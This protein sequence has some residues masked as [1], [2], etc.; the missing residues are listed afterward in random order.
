MMQLTHQRHL[1]RG[2]TRSVNLDEVSFGKKSNLSCPRRM[3]G[4]GLQMADGTHV[5]NFSFLKTHDN[6]SKY[7]LLVFGV[8]S[9]HKSTKTRAMG[10]KTIPTPKNAGSWDSEHENMD[11]GNLRS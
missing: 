4:T 3:K 1:E 5:S 9:P 6:H 2:D 10:K 7:C 8:F 11:L